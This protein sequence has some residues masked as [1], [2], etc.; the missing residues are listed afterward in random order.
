MD[1]WK[2]G[3]IVKWNC[4]GELDFGRVTDVQNDS[5]R[6]WWA[7]D[8]TQSDHSLPN[9]L[10]VVVGFDGPAPPAPGSLSDHMQKQEKL[11]DLLR[12]E[13]DVLQGQ[14]DGLTRSF[15][16]QLAEL[17]ELVDAKADEAPVPQ[18]LTDRVAQLE[19]NDDVIFGRLRDE[20]ER[21]DDFRDELSRHLESKL[22]T[23]AYYK[24]GGCRS[25]VRGEVEHLGKVTRV[26]RRV[27]P[28]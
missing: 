13:V 7:R 9:K 27:R 1:E 14:V 3:Q 18:K 6:I 26:V 12:K 22:V 24:A 15:R 8:R 23:T 16:N 4:A 17:R 20:K 28:K 5:L 2:V 25:V 21:L 19:K 11:V 10:I